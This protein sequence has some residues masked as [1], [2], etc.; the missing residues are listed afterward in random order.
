VS[1]EN[2]LPNVSAIKKAIKKAI[3]KWTIK[4]W[5]LGSAEMPGNRVLKI[6][7]GLKVVSVSIKVKNA[8]KPFA[9]LMPYG[10]FALSALLILLLTL[11]ADLGGYMVYQW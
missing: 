8:S 1:F 6:S 2:K 9:G 7:A 10:H 11:G 3:G 5:I 4:G